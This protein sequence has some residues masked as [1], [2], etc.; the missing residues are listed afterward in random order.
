MVG[1]SLVVI[2]RALTVLLK[3]RGTKSKNSNVG[4]GRSY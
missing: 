3:D 4:C 2:L 1:L